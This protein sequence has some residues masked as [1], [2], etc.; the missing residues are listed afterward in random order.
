MSVQSLSS[1]LEQIQFQSQ[2]IADSIEHSRAFQSKEA[3]SV[4]FS[5][6]LFSSINDINQLQNTAKMQSQDFVSGATDIGLN[7][8]M[9][10]MQKSSLALSLG[11]QARN[12]LVGAYQ[13]IMNMAV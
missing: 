5:S 8:V 1:V 12:K 6:L 2:H 13:E 3:P 9:V 4:S 10:T 11:V 7:D